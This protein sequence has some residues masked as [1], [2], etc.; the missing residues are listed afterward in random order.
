VT[1]HSLCCWEIGVGSAT[2]A[3]SGH[4]KL[5]GIGKSR[6]GR[7]ATRD[8]TVT[9]LGRSLDIASL[10]RGCPS[11]SSRQLGLSPCFPVLAAAVCCNIRVYRMILRWWRAQL[12]DQPDTDTRKR[13]NWQLPLN[14]ITYI[15]QSCLR[16]KRPGSDEHVAEVFRG[17]KLGRIVALLLRTTDRS[18]WLITIVDVHRGLTS[19][20]YAPFSQ[21]YVQML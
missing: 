18:D 10:L 9:F 19:S 21:S 4:D 14:C 15:H 20:T 13:I 1:Y 5:R 17:D 3:G 6:S 11:S 8:A 2:T 16:P 12:R 7:L